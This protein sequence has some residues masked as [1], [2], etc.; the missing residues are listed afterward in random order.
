MLN[1][2]L[3]ECYVQDNGKGRAASAEMNAQKENYHKSTALRVTQER[4]AGLNK[5]ADFVP[6]EI[7]DLKD[8]KGNPSGT[9][10]VFR[11][12]I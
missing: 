12:S 7:I 2:H 8:E 10:V 6:F 3:L 1:E 9:K 5:D 11:L 4:L